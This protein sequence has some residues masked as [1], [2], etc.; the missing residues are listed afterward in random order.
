MSESPGE[1]ASTACS[2]ILQ[3]RI[4][5]EIPHHVFVYQPLKIDTDAAIGADDDIRANARVRGNVAQRIGDAAVSAVEGDAAVLQRRCRMEEF[6][7]RDS[8]GH[9]RFRADYRP[10]NKDEKPKPTHPEQVP[11]ESRQHDVD[12]PPEAGNLAGD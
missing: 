11:S 6:R 10:R 12:Q 5:R 1:I 3:F 4:D 2:I 7:G 9:R 8:V